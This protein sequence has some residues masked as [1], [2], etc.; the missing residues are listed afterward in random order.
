MNKK[1][2]REK[3]IKKYLNGESTLNI[4]TRVWVKEKPGFIDSHAFIVVVHTFRHFDHPLE[5]LLVPLL[6]WHFDVFY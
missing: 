5:L 2:L 6:M 3:V 1:S 4:F